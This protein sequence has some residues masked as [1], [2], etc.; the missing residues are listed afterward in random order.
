M[1]A[2]CVCC[3]AAAERG[4]LDHELG[5]K[6]PHPTCDYCSPLTLDELA[7]YREGISR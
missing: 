4:E 1:S 2:C 6:C 3:V 7:A 5:D